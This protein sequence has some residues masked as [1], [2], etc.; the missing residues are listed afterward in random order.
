MVISAGISQIGGKYRLR[1]DLLELTPLHAFFISL[2]CGAC[3]YE[4]NKPRVQYECFN[5][6]NSEYI[7]Y[8]EVVKCFPNRFDK[9]KEG[10]LGLVSQ[11][12]FNDIIKGVLVPENRIERAYFF[13]LLNKMGYSGTTSKEKPS[14]A[15]FRGMKAPATDEK[16]KDFEK[17]FRGI[18]GKNE[19]G[20]KGLNPK[21]TRPFS[22]NDLGILTPID[23]EAV[24]RLR[25]TLLTKYDFRHAYKLFHK[26]YHIKKGLTSQC[27][28]FVDPPYPSTEKYYGNF[29]K[30][31]DHYDLIDI[32]INS[33]FLFLLTIGCECGF[34]LDALKEA[35]WYI[36]KL[37]VK[38]STD[39]GNQQDSIEYA[40][41]NF[42]ISNELPL[43]K[44]EYKQKVLS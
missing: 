37:K 11:Q 36:K 23:K 1:K 8:L 17:K 34:Y 10:V 4:L 20:F 33:P 44:Y 30:E 14:D 21:T 12:I 32:M 29:F 13:Y 9:L 26:G 2:F 40:C 7:N 27:F 22:N 5:D 6:I 3:W 25:Y 31:Q 38:Y 42:K 35:G 28:V 43:M 39:A 18:V 16:I 24:E 15:N 41:T 19:V